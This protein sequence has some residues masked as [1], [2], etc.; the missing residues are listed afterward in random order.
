MLLLV[1]A[2]DAEREGPKASYGDHF[3]VT[4]TGRVVGGS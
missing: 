1:A 3:L 4:M 2:L